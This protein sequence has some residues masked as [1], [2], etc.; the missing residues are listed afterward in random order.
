M[1]S[2]NLCIFLH[3]GPVPKARRYL[4]KAIVLSLFICQGA[5]ANEPRKIV[6][7][8]WIGADLPAFSALEQLYR[9]SF[10][11]LGYE[12]AMVSKPPLRSL[13]EANSGTTDG[14]CARVANYLDAAPGSPLQRVNVMIA[15]TN[16]DAWSYDNTIELNGPLSLINSKYRI[17]YG[18]GTVAMQLLLDR[19]PLKNLQPVSSIDLG[20][21]MLVR[22]RFDV[23]ISPR[24]IFKQELEQNPIDVELYFVG[25]ILELEGYPYLHERHT[26]LMADFTEELSKRVP[27]GGLT[28]P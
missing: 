8:C 13:A 16:L 7:S 2:V 3:A 14:E 27:E 19:M 17:A 1:S 28:L 26:A 9:D 10:A 24:A 22:K 5:M 18:K 6:F 4:I 15:K 11:A 20:I 25:T 23:L 12:F 21:K